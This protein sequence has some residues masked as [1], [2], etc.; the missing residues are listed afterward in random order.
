VIRAHRPPTVP[1]P[2]L[3][4]DPEIL[5]GYLEDA[6]GAG[7][8]RASG[9]V[10]PESEAEAA[11]FLRLARERGSSVLPQAARSS[12]TGGAV[13][14]GEVVVST[15]R[16]TDCDGLGRWSSGARWR[17]GPGVRL[18]ELQADLAARG[19]YYPPVPTYDEAMLGGTISTN[20][21]GAATFKY[22]ATRRW[23]HGLRVLLFNGDLLLI[24]R[25]ESQA[26]PG[27]VF[28]IGLSDGAELRVPAPRYRLPELKKLSAGYHAA[29]PL[30]L[31]DLFVGA[32]GTLG[33]ISGATIEVVPLP[34][35]VLTGVVFLPSTPRALAL[36]AALRDAALAARRGRDPLG[37]DV[38]AIEWLDGESLQILRRSGAARRLRVELPVE[39]GG[40]LL[41]ELELPRPLGAA[42]AQDLVAASFEQRPACA[43]HPVLR[44]CAILGDHG[45]L[46]ALELAWP[47][48]E[49]RRGEL[50][51]LREAVPRCVAEIL[52]ERRR[53]GGGVEKVG[54][55]LIVPCERLPEMVEVYREGFRRRGL[56]FAL[57]GHVADGNLHPNALPNDADE[58]RRGFD[59][60]LE[61][62]AEAARR[63]GSPLSEHGVGRNAVKQELLRR[64]LGDG[65]L[66]EMRRIKLA[67]DPDRRFAPGVLFAAAR[68]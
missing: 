36:A 18:R 43:D 10:R 31:V 60:L 47:G 28:R 7:P 51:E 44:L 42:A 22:G 24:E 59:A 63:G 14:H 19:F 34:P 15:E 61:F 54:G 35:A 29:D 40:A 3:I 64:F 39:A 8:G 46:D 57:W 56:E 58:V 32:E 9:L 62:G 67:L 11:A 49:R 38:R 66:A 33:L 53:T 27:E 55:D 65:A 68:S 20:A 50:T 37:P 16:L 26:R 2:P 30:D 25:G 4:D 1:P 23:I 21:G 13:P 45:A 5:E 48:D 6:S 12:L 41:F 52:T 17:A